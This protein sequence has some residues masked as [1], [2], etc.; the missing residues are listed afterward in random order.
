LAPGKEADI[1]LID[2]DNVHLFPTH[3]VFGTVVQGGD[4][5]FVHSVFVA[6][7]LIKH[8]GELLGIDFPR[9]KAAVEES[10]DYLF[11]AVNWPREKID[12]VD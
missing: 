1:V 8:E 2:T 4:V 5:E 11:K 12:F 6:G 10:R 3:N 9:L 7:R